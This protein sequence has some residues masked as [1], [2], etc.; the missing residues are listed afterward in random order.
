[1]VLI[2]DVSSEYD[3]DDA[4]GNVGSAEGIDRAYYQNFLIEICASLSAQG[5]C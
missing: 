4:L 2:L 3:A 5:A 1:M